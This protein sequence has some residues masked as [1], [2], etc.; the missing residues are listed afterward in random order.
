MA[1]TKMTDDG[2]PSPNS[3]ILLGTH[4]IAHDSRLVGLQ[5]AGLIAA[6][7][8]ISRFID[9]VATDPFLN[10]KFFDRFQEDDET[11]YRLRECYRDALFEPDLNAD[12]V[13][14][15]DTAISKHPFAVGVAADVRNVSL[16]SFVEITLALMAMDWH[17]AMIGMAILGGTSFVSSLGVALGTDLGK[18]LAKRVDHLI[19][20]DPRPA[21]GVRGRITA[22]SPR[23]RKDFVEAVDRDYRN[24]AKVRS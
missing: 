21:K 9:W 15:I 8:R 1:R 7:D 2:G 11:F 4:L 18:L 24:D 5:I 10:A 22:T 3:P 20:K 13:Q 23:Q 17:R 12:M 14:T 19:D 6:A 16:G